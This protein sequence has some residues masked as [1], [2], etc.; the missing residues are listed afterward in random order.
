MIIFKKKKLKF[1]TKY[2]ICNK[3]IQINPS[4]YEKNYLN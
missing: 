3:F 4:D 1:K 2:Y